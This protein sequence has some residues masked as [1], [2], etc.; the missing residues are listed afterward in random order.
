MLLICLAAL[1]AGCDDGRAQADVRKQRQAE[2]QEAA[3]AALARTPEARTYRFDGNELKVIETPVRDA[4]GYV[5]VQRCFVWRDQ[6]FKTAA[7]SC[8]QQPEVLLSN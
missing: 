6:E 1:A 2:R 7:I 8:G 5:D 3:E 4:T